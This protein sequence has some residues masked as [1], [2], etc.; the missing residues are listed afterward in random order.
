MS[1]RG[2]PDVRLRQGSTNI[3]ILKWNLKKWIVRVE[4]E[5]TGIGKGL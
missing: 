5:L 1:E 2:K 3:P 4:T